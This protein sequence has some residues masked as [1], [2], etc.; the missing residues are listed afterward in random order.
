MTSPPD[1]H[2]PISTPT[3]ISFD[4]LLRLLAD[5]ATPPET[6]A[7]YLIVDPDASGAFAPV[8]VANPA[9]V[10][11]PE[12]EAAVFMAVLNGWSRRVRLKRYRERRARDPNVTRLVSE[13][14]SWFQYP[15]LL[16][17]VVDQLNRDH[18]VYCTAAAGDML[19]DMIAQDEVVAA[20]LAEKP[21]AILVSAGGNDLLGKI[22]TL[23][24]PFDPRRTPEDY[25]GTTFG[26]FLE[27]LVTD[28]RRFLLRLI[29]HAE[30]APIFCHSYDYALPRRGG[31]WL[32]R[33][34]A[35]IGI[36]DAT[37][38][39]TIVGLMV[40]RFHA[41][42]A[43]VVQQASF[44]GR[45]TLV[46]CRRSVPADGWHDELHPNDRG[47]ALVADRFRA[48]FSRALPDASLESMERTGETPTRPAEEEAMTEAALVLSSDF[49]ETAL[50]HEIGRRIEL[51]KAD[52]GAST[53]GLAEVSSSSYEGVF[54]A[55]RD[56]GRSV[57]KRVYRELA[58]VAC[59]GGA[60][61]QGPEARLAAAIE[62]GR[63][64]LARYLVGY[65][66]SVAALPVAVA[67]VA[68]A[69]VLRSVVESNLPAAC[70]AWR[71][72]AAEP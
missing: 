20:V 14:D 45:V 15:F 49:D 28:Y 62:A 17:D 31:R 35:S 52:P 69:I 4:E 24:E 11:L 27:A 53:I 1:P 41:A 34:M 72:K 39:R 66:G 38:Q 42:M 70:A 61:G 8:V 57:M 30:S 55:F 59:G 29:E 54:D 40:D 50:L 9:L 23:I 58:T 51:I 2:E 25:L 36:T 48:A 12:F 22:Q 67:T 47:Y 44:V 7:P 64:A 19:T 33:P 10:E 32:G 43:S 13:G 63:I 6:L 65:F 37:L 5:P 16:Q 71:A 68:A 3:R 46:D 21:A 56:I 18:A 26:A 60:S